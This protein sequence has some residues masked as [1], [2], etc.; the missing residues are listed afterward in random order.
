MYFRKY[1]AELVGTFALTLAVSLSLLV[2]MPLVTVLVAGLTLG[3]A[4]YTVG[5]ISG[6]HLNPAVTLGLASV[7]KI[8]GRDA[9]LYIIFQLLGAMLAMLAAR[10]IT[11]EILAVLTEDTLVVGA[12][13]ALGAAV[14]VFCV[15]AV[16]YKKV[17]SEASGLVVG[18]SLTLGLLMTAG[19]SNGVLNPAV[20]I[21]IGSI[22]LMYLFA[23]IVGGV[24]AAWLYKYLVNK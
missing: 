6:A 17:D 18:G 2:G 16:A 5:P 12:V 23:P 1:V 7:K 15:S 10:G 4:V 24:F 20:A 22:S 14:L 9:I 19:F 21:G 13:E 8:S 3:L 11:G